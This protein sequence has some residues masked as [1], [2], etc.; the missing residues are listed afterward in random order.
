MGMAGTYIAV[1]ELLLRH[2]CLKKHFLLKDMI[3]H[4]RHYRPLRR[5]YTFRYY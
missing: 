2:I 4:I 3:S 5:K 1:E